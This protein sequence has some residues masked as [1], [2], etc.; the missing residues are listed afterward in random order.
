MAVTARQEFDYNFDAFA[1]A[2]KREE[3]PKQPKLKRL[4]PV[5]KTEAQIK[6]ESKTALIRMVR[7]VSLSLAFTVLAVLNIYAYC[8]SDLQDRK[9]DQLTE[10][11][12]MVQSENTRLSMEL[13]S[14]VSLEQIEKIAV[15]QLGLVKLD[16]SEI[17]YVRLSEGSKV[18]VSSGKTAE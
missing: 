5:V 18:L 17:E 7:N 2:R 8:Q 14:M 9:Y 6:A 12:E 10:Q 1:P 13:N 11:Y 4:D 15:E 3:Q 16:A